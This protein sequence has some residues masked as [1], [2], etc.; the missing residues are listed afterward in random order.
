MF[1]RY[2]SV[3]WSGSDHEDRR[4]NL[5][6]VEATPRGNNG[7]VVPPPEARKGVR[8]W[9]RAECRRWLAQTLRVDQPRCLIAM[10]FGFGYPWGADVSV[11]GSDRWEGMLGAVSGLY[12][13]EG[14]ARAVAQK[15][16]SSQS[17]GG[18]GPY[19][20][21]DTRT[22]FRFYLDNATPYY[23]LVE[24]AV[25]QAISQW[26]LG[27]GGTVGFSSI[28][29]MAALHHL[30][31]M[32][33]QGEVD[34]RVWP[35][36]GFAPEEDKHVIVESYPA[37]YPEPPDYGGCTDEHCRDAWR[38]LQWM[39]GHHENEALGDYFDIAPVPF[40]RVENVSFDEQVRF[41]GWI[42]GVR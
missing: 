6:V 10:D 40:G 32:R 30:M 41:E 19:R 25:P 42:F 36:E 38:V 8:A 27:S 15:I 33:G 39:L 28:T 20:F 21:N 9:A 18:H 22:D 17:F 29:G 37:I 35:Q 31:E 2:I 11:F 34:F 12:A 7:T 23:R 16:N 5:R 26:Y 13:E 4:V 14:T 1:K 24:M 3:D